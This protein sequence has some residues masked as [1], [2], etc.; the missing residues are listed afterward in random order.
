MPSSSA[1]SAAAAADISLRSLCHLFKEQGWGWQAATC[2]L[3]TYLQ[4]KHA[5]GPSEVIPFVSSYLEPHRV[6]LLHLTATRVSEKQPGV[7][8]LFL[9]A[10]CPWVILSKRC[11]YCVPCISLG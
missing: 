5:K 8:R 1:P 2:Q 3:Q 4:I 10:L 7:L 9:Q 6:L 11:H